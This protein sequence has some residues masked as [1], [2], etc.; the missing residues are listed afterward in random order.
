MS[1]CLLLVDDHPLFLDALAS[2][3][4]TAFPSHHVATA[5]SLASALERIEQTEGIVGIL[6]DLR[7]PDTRGL[8]GLLHL[9]AAHP[10][11]KIAVI[12]AFCD[13]DTIRKAQV[14]GACTFVEKSSRPSDF[15]SA[16]GSMVQCSPVTLPL[17]SPVPP[18]SR[19]N[20]PLT[21]KQARVLSLLCSGMLNKQIAYTLEIEETTV[22]A[23]ISEILRKLNV[24][25]RT[26]A[27]VEV[28]SL[29][30]DMAFVT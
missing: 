4:Q 17:P 7:L 18:S 29:K 8:E 11:L 24:S 23:H 28:L 5:H 13:T 1:K 30:C 27:L 10:H 14:L 26:Q 25:S 16:I 6:L 20:E 21:P 2:L 19:D 12:S 3:V 9:H 22:K 15:I